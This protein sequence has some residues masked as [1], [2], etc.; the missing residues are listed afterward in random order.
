L[1]SLGP[2]PPTDPRQGLRSDDPR[3]D[4]GSLLGPYHKTAIYDIS[5]RKVYL[6]DGRALEAHSGLGAKRDDP[7]FVH[8]KMQ[9]ATPPNVYD[10]TLRESL[11][12]GVRALRLNPV[13]GSKMH[14]RDGILAHTYMLGPSG[15]SNGC[16]SFRNYPVFLQAYLKGDV[17]RL[18]VVS[19]LAGPPPNVTMAR[20]ADS[21][22]VASSYE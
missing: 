5:A 10:L 6:P 8:V 21:E 17:K 14:G 16:V 19:R 12:H 2:L 3:R 9:G 13:A 1:A 4:P 22:R 7:R 11:F 20:G 18:I 15:Q